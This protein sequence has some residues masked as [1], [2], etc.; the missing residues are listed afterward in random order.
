MPRETSYY[1]LLLGALGTWRITHLLVV[2]DGPR[3][4]LVALRRGAG[5]GA[6]GKLLDCF[7]CSSLWIAA[8]FAMLLGA[9]WRH[10][11]L[12]WPA[13]SAA[14]ILLERIQRR[15]PAT[16]PARYSEDLAESEEEEPDVL[17][18]QSQ[19]ELESD[20]PGPGGA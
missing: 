18:R 7:Y 12:L 10:R 20:E 19:G 8:P 15:Q 5:G 4:L 9:S 13:L 3:D 2:E 6:W 14:A 17:L 1:L 11:L 16:P